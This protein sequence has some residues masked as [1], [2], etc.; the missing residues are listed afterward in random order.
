MV[1]IK[2]LEM[3]GFKTFARKTT[4]SFDK[5]L[6]VIVGPNGSGKTNIV[7]AINF[8][9]GELSVRA[10]RATNF[11]SLI[12]HGNSEIPKSK[13][14]SV[15]IHLDNS[16]RR[17]PIDSDVVTITRYLGSDGTSIYRVNGKRYSRNDLLNL[18]GHASLVGGM[19]IISQGTTMKIADFS[20]EDRRK[21]VE[22]IIGIAEYDRKKEEAQVQLREAELNLKLALG[23]FEEVKKRLIELEKER[24]DL[25]RFN[26]LK[27]ELRKIKAIET[28][29]K[30]GELKQRI[31]EV[32][33]ELKAKEEKLQEYRA[34]RES[35]EAQR[36]AKEREWQEFTVKV[37]DKGGD[38]LLLLQKEIGDLNSE[39]VGLKT[40][41]STATTN[42]KSYENMRSKKI[43]NLKSL[44]RQITENRKELK[45][46]EKSKEEIEK[47]LS[48]KKK[49]RNEILE[50]INEIKGSL[51]ENSAK[52]SS[53]EEEI[54]NLERELGRLE[55][56]IRAEKESCLILEDQ[57]NTLQNRRQAFKNLYESFSERLKQVN[58]LKEKEQKAFET[59]I[60][61][62]NR[63]KSQIERVEN[64]IKNAEKTAKKAR[65]SVTEFASRR[66]LADAVL[67][68][69][70]A[71]EHLENLSSLK[72][73]RGIHGRLKQKIRI[74]HGYRKAVEAAA[75]GWLQA[76]IVEDMNVVK[77]CAETLKR[78][79]IGR[80][81][82]LP[83]SNL[84]NVKSI[85][86]PGLPGILGPA[87]SFVT[88]SA[89]YQP[90]VNFVL[91]D[92][93]VAADEKSALMASERGF[94]VVTVE[95]EVFQP[96]LRLEVGF[97]REPI[98]LSEILPSETTIKSISETVN[99]FE[100]LL[101]NRKSDLKRLGNELLRLESE[102]VAHEDNLRFFE[103]DILDLN[104]NLERIHKNIVEIDRKIRSL[105]HKIEKSRGWIAGAEARKTEILQKLHG[106]RVEAANLR[107]KLKPETITGLE[108]ENTKLEAEIGGLQRQL[109]ELKTKISM[110]NSNLEN[111]LLPSLDT[112]RREI[113]G[114][115]ENLRKQK[116][117]LKNATEKLEK[118]RERLRLLEREKEELSAQ[119]M[120][121]REEHKKFVDF[122]EEINRQI[123]KLDG[124]IEPINNAVNSLKQELLKNQLELEHKLKELKA[125][126]YEEELSDV[127]REEYEALKPMVNSLQKE[128]ESLAE[129]VNMNALVLYEPQKKNYKELSVRINQIEAE[130]REILKFIETVENEKKEAFFEALEKLKAKF[131]ETF[132]AITGGRGWLQ[133][134]NPDEPFSGGLDIIVEFPGK[135]LMP[136]TAASG[137]EK[138]VVAVCY[139]FALQSLAKSS[140]FYIFDEIDA[141]LDPVNT[142]RL[143]ELLARE[144]KNSQII[145]ISFKE[146]MAEKADRLFGIYAKNGV[147]HVYSLPAV[148]VKT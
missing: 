81:K 64:E 31:K 54:K 55:V 76:L 78:A 113:L 79:K 84:K 40:T 147:S 77:A 133:L 49:R 96:G 141:H 56:K 4:I 124:E 143:A 57:L 102:K 100:R 99:S 66:D 38:R 23:K 22:S 6:N 74:S 131:S 73:L 88:C 107:K 105:T 60:Q 137:G 110:Y 21:N 83:L 103:R 87:T 125:L 85:K 68:E 61:A 20:P 15:T 41:I 11:S 50:K 140:P 5:G 129:R 17:I 39:I 92:T 98:D 116:I 111:I 67:S 51:E 45:R 127:D 117:E 126:G 37:T 148:R 135:P 26:Y 95:G 120:A 43:E 136:V 33:E 114:I 75:E 142:Q 82:L 144:S 106:L 52:L 94:R 112:V 32:E 34:K 14:A 8:V 10:L 35:L 28:S 48:E 1:S 132:N 118:A 109:D 115:G 58:S 19:N 70:K 62:I 2:R 36:S 13:Y 46:I 59:A 91:G 25:L 119:M 101:E 65:I 63:I 3:V 69:E 80:V 123:K 42:I 97:Y 47:I 24:N 29:L 71:L 93:L 12:F 138:S 130:K 53:I 146:A 122:I 72:V 27:K 90:A 18:L 44:R 7:D 145:V 128:Y 86:N 9:F 104:Q 16:S 134:Q 30:I 121:K 108:A 139:I 89:K